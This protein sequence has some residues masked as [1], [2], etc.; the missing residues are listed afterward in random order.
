MKGVKKCPM[1]WQQLVNHNIMPNKGG[2]L[3]TL[4]NSDLFLCNK[5]FYCETLCN[6]N[7]YCTFVKNK[8]KN[9]NKMYKSKD[10]KSLA[11]S[12]TLVTKNKSNFSFIK[13]HLFYLIPLG[14]FYI[15]ALLGIL[16]LI[17]I[18]FS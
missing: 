18:F 14:F 16:N 13:H 4:Y 1:K 5:N 3:V 2:R 8:F 15:G 10:L 9:S 11:A 6:K 7:F 12:S 17:S